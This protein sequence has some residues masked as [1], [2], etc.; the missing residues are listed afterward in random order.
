MR[1]NYG[2]PHAGGWRR[3]WGVITLV[4]LLTLPL[5]TPRIYAADEIKY[6]APLRSLWFDG[7]IHYANEYGRYI[8]R[9]PVAHAGL[10]PFYEGVTSTG[11]RLNDAP[12]GS[13]LLWAPFYVAADLGV[14]LARWLGFEVPRDGYGW[15]YVL[16]VC[17]GSLVWGTLGMLLTYRLCRELTGPGSATTA[18]VGLWLASPVIF[19]LYITPPMAHA[20][21]L[22]T[23]ALFLFLWYQTREER[24]WPEWAVLGASAG[25]MILVREL[26]WLLLL[27]P[28]IDEVGELLEDWRLRRLERAHGAPARGGLDAYAVGRR[29]AGYVA[30]ALVL[31]VTVSPQFLVYRTLHGSYSPTPFVVE[32]FSWPLHSLQVLLSGFHGLFTW[33]PITLLGALGLL[34]L[35][36]RDHRMAVAFGA[37]FVTQVLVVGSYDTWPGGASFG[38]RRFI[39]CTPMFAIGLAAAI[40]RLATRGRRLAAL[41]VAF[42]VLWNLG[43]ALQYG[44]GMIPRDE[45]VRMRTIVYNQLFEVPGRVADV[46]WRFLSDR[47]SLYRTRS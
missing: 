27:V 30:F 15:P 38:A 4:V 19:Y 23:V 37:V 1:A 42:L 9:D 13:A 16:A 34:A 7:D 40:D 10:R 3:E 36:A 28:A 2:R 45:R 46:A 8:E 29:I 21:S 39:N 22:F 31:A 11:H 43:L 35:A 6:F 41:L 47:S 20:N 33:T 18:T 26:N 17:L 25:L 32:K 14:G 12:I 24:R 5:F 44:T